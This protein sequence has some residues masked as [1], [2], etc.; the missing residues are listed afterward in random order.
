MSSQK[1]AVRLSNAA[2]RLTV[3]PFK[4]FDRTAPGI[5]GN[6]W[7]W[8]CLGFTYSLQVE[9]VL[10]IWEEMKWDDCVDIKG[11]LKERGLLWKETRGTKKR[12]SKWER[13]KESEGLLTQQELSAKE[14][15]RQG[16][17]VCFVCVCVCVCNVGEIVATCQIQWPAKLAGH[18]VVVSECVCVCVGMCVC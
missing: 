16:A 14:G 3:K 8:E 15:V 2:T 6:G 9:D 10:N 11:T 13:K 5:G 12:E 1:H 18:R 7:K 17:S 4:G